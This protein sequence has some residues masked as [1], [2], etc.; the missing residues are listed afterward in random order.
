MQPNLEI[1]LGR[2][3]GTLRHGIRVFRGIPYAAP[4]VGARRFR[5][6]EEPEPWGGVRDATRAGATAPQPGP[7]TFRGPLANLIGGGPES[8]DCLTLNVWTPGTDGARR[9]VMVWIHGGA[10]VIGSGRTLVYSGSRLARQGDVVVVTLNYR[11]GALGFAHLGLTG[12]P[13]LEDAAN[14]G[15]QDQIAALRFVREHIAAFGGDP[16]NVTVFGES[17]GAM[18]VG[19]LLGA[20]TARPLFRRAI[21]QSGAAHNVSSRERGA[22]AAEIFLREL[23]ATPQDAQRVL[24]SAPVD[25]I[26]AAQQRA[27]V[28]LGLAHGTLPWQPAVDG[29]V[30]PRQP[31]AAIADGEARAIPILAGTNRDE[32]KLFTLFDAKTRRIDESG[33]RRRLARILP[34]AGDEA[35]E[36]YRRSAEGGTAAPLALWEAIQADRI[37]R[38]PASR[39]AELQAAHQPATYKY[40][41]D[42]TPRLGRDR[43]GACHA[44]EIPFVFGTIGHPAM[45]VLLGAAGGAQALSRTMREAWLSFARSGEPR[46]DALGK[47]APYDARERSTMRIGRHFELLRAPLD[48]LRSFWHPHLAEPAA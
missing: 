30:V 13:G 28:A 33:L 37:F 5:P 41:F 48:G 44:L 27:S 10:F 47:W 7:R 8:E 11:L 38:Y 16:D 40:L 21:L 35:F 32:W 12:A 26:L 36:L 19:T 22:R 14:L 34:D 42:W 18:S 39:L 23:G 6:P 43:I 20:P 25:A 3:R 9:P 45:R 29:R 1:G 2:L 4:P 17:A 24:A 15:I 31:L 46:S